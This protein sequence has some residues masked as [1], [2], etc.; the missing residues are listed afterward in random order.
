[1]N[2]P[3]DFAALVHQN[4]L[5]AMAL[6]VGSNLAAH[7][8]VGHR[9]HEDQEPAGQRDVAGDARAL[10]GDGLLG[11][12][13]QDLLAGLQQVGD[14]RQVRSLRRAAR[15]SAPAALGAAATL[16]ASAAIAALAVRGEP[17]A[18][19]GSRFLFLFGLE[20]FVLAALFVEVQLDA[21]VEVSFLQHLAQF[22]GA[23]LRGQR[24]FFVII[25]VVHL[26][27][28]AACMGRRVELLAFDDLFFDEALARRVR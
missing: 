13:H 21:M 11:N 8:H 18:S 12:L 15:R 9:G 14:D 25:E 22:A 7:A 20:L 1:M 28:V 26:G 27:L 24:L 4:P 23:K 6:L 5:Q 16:S 10:L 17:A 19:P 3:E 2:P